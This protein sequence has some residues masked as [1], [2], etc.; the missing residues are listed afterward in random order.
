MIYL[1]RDEECIKIGLTRESNLHRRWMELQIGN[2]RLIQFRVWDMAGEMVMEKELH[3]KFSHLKIRGEWFM[4]DHDLE[5]M[6]ER[7][8]IVR[9]P[10]VVGRP[11]ATRERAM[12][13]LEAQLSSGPMLG[14]EVMTKGGQLGFSSKTIR[15]AADRIGVLRPNKKLLPEQMV[16]K[17]K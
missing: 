10:K 7:A 8:Q 5:A 11:P 9:L 4:I 3:Q 16:W 13:W 17:M 1:A 6:W 12:V 14:E 15:R 2:P